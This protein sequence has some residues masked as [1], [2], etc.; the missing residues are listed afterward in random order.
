MRRA[1]IDDVIAAIKRE[2]AY[3]DSKW[4]VIESYETALLTWMEYIEEELQ[5][6]AI[7]G[8]R[9]DIPNALA[10]LVQV[11]AVTVA[12]LEQLGV[13]ERSDIP[14]VKK[15]VGS[16][17]VCAF[18]GCELLVCD[19]DMELGPESIKYCQKHSQQSDELIKSQNIA[20]L[21][22]FWANSQNQAGLDL[23]EEI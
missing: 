1:Q 7:A 13:V 8:L 14:A 18:I 5:E 16:R 19:E 20:E 23:T 22:K 3:Q 6:A 12:C 11:A 21:L 9:G 15:A 17:P 10:E 4:G 2:R